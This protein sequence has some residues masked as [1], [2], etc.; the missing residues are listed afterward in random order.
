MHPSKFTKIPNVS[1]VPVEGFAGHLSLSRCGARW[2]VL[3]R[4]ISR[5]I[6]QPTPYPVHPHGFSLPL[7][8]ATFVISCLP[9]PTMR[10]EQQRH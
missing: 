4:I 8:Q 7:S 1:P 6:A 5:A 9:P 10:L 2:R 3:L